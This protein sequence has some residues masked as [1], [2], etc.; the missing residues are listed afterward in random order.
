MGSVP[1]Q[2]VCSAQPCE[3]GFGAVCDRMSALRR[4]LGRERS[5]GPESLP[6]ADSKSSDLAGSGCIIKNWVLLRI[7]ELPLGKLAF[8][9]SSSVYRQ[10]SG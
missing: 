10:D 4:H 2:S 6:G 3:G 5:A 1:Q 8:P 9:R 7:K